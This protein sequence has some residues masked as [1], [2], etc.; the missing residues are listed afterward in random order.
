MGRSDSNSRATF[1]PQSAPVYGNRRCASSTLSGLSS[2][3][4]SA[5]KIDQCSP[6]HQQSAVG[7]PSKIQKQTDTQKSVQDTLESA[8]GATLKPGSQKKET[9]ESNTDIEN[10]QVITEE[11]Q[12]QSLT[13]SLPLPVEIVDDSILRSRKASDTFDEIPSNSMQKQADTTHLTENAKDQ[14][15]YGQGRTGHRGYRGNPRWADGVG[16]VQ[17]TGPLISPTGP[18]SRSPVEFIDSLLHR[19]RLVCS[20]NCTK[21]IALT[22]FYTPPRDLYSHSWCLFFEKILKCLLKCVLTDFG[23]LT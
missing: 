5:L 1:F 19:I 12:T 17:N 20:K 13:Q 22:E 15:I 9:I 2:D 6:G 14:S 18:P 11:S 16:I 3:H 21:V 23:S 7:T 4:S 10:H 8:S